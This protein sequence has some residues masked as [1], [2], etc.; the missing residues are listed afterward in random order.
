MVGVRLPTTDV[1]PPGPHRDLVEAIHELYREAG[2]P[3]TRDIS[4]KSRGRDDLL[5]TISH[6]TVSAILRGKGGVP[7]WTKVECLVRV[8]AARAVGRPDEDATVQRFHK[9]WSAAAGVGPAKVTPAEVESPR[10]HANDP[11]EDTPGWDDLEYLRRQ[12]VGNTG[13]AFQLVDR[14][15]ARGDTGGLWE[16]AKIGD[17]HAADRLADVLAERDELELLAELADAG[18]EYAAQL[19]ANKLAERG[20][21]RGL[22]VRAGAG[23]AFAARPLLVLLRRRRWQ[24]PKG[25]VREGDGR[26]DLLAQQGNVVRLAE[27]AYDGN[28]YAEHMLDILLSQRRVHRPPAG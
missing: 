23:D 20:D 14:L 8:L 4:K 5:D 21:F 1:L 16:R 17:E 15:A 11:A 18:Y 28:E 3:S 24:R 26:V 12:A 7:H 9:L 27:E 13:A 2:L 22:A 19:L 10:P 25:A 6:E